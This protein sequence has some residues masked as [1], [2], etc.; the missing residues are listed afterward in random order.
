MALLL[1]LLLRE[2]LGLE[3]ARNLESMT[4]GDIAH[5]DLK[6]QPAASKQTPA[7][8]AFARAEPRE[9]PPRAAEGRVKAVVPAHGVEF[10]AL[11]ETQVQ[12]AKGCEDDCRMEHSDPESDDFQQCKDSCEASAEATPGT[13]ENRQAEKKLGAE[14]KVGCDNCLKEESQGEVSPE[15]K[16]RMEDCKTVEALLA[17]R[18]AEDRIQKLQGIEGAAN[19]ELKDL[20]EDA[21]GSGVCGVGAGIVVAW[22]LTL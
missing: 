20:A 21:E 18:G 6:M 15:C 17:K 7:A 22:A 3:P 4:S 13:P 14:A 19:Q 12:R 1:W 10:I 16:A 2:T 11:A 9:E 8:P 5:E